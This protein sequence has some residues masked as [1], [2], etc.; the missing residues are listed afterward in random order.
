M[1]ESILTYQQ[2]KS[3]KLL[4]EIDLEKLFPASAPKERDRFDKNW[5]D[6]LESD[7]CNKDIFKR[8]GD[9]LKYQSEQL[10]GLW[11]RS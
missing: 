8:K 1:T 7:P 11:G 6:F 10:M 3:V 2:K 4:C 9:L 5:N